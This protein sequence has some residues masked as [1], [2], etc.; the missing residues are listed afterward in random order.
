MRKLWT[1]SLSLAV[2]AAV[3][4][5][6]PAAPAA[7][8]KEKLMHPEALTEKAPDAFKVKFE[9][10][11][12]NL[13]VEVRR[14][15][16]PIGADRFYNLVKNGYYDGVKFFRVLSGFM[17]QFGIHGDPSLARVWSSANIKDDPV[18]ESNKRGYLTYAKTGAPNS[19]STQLF[20]NYGDNS[21][22]DGQGF[23]PFGKVVEG[24]E[25]VDKLHSGYGEGAPR[26]SGPDQ[27]RIRAEGNAYLEKDFPNLDAV[28]KAT[29]VP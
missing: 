23:A 4:M 13:V 1:G 20:I 19:R 7:P 10:T 14:D 3:T 11:K 5:L 17:A 16:A 12:G 9:T 25:V 27:G 18:K 6:A 2:A 15:W 21:G 24:M 29:I 22:L 26:G 28:K 8:D